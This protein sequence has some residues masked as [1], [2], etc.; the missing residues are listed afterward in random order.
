MRADENP[1]NSA[2]TKKHKKNPTAPKPGFEPAT[3]SPNPNRRIWG[4]EPG[5]IW[6]CENDP[7]LNHRI[8]GF[9]PKPPAG[10]G[11]SELG[12]GKKAQTDLGLRNSPKPEPPD[13]GV[14]S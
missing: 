3:F 11:V 1:L 13:L 2:A 10:F 5:P 12:S 14:R 7:N 6:G 8:W 4:F 9:G